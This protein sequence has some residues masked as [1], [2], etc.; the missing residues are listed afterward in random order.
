MIALTT[1]RARQYFRAASLDLSCLGSVPSS[2]TKLA[3]WTL[4]R[5][6]QTALER[7]PH[8]R[9]RPCGRVLLRDRAIADWE[10]DS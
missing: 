8:V 9:Q 4:Q 1:V 6:E 3:G 10:D 2:N 5:S 7:A